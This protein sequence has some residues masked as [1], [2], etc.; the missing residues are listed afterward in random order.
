MGSELEELS[1]Y[2]LNIDD[3]NLSILRQNTEIGLFK[4]EFEDKKTIQFTN[5]GYGIIEFLTIQKNDPYF[6]LYNLDKS[7]SYYFFGMTFIN[8][9]GF[10]YMDVALI[11]NEIR[12][13][14]GDYF[15]ILFEDGTKEKYTFQ[16]AAKGDK[17]L[18][19]NIITLTPKDLFNFL[20]KKIDKVKVVSARKNVY[21]IYCLNEKDNKPSDSFKYKYTSRKTGQYLLNYM[22]YKFI[23]FNLQNKT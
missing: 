21:C 16:R 17:Y 3:E 23:D 13:A 2:C 5:V 8:H 1:N 20:T 10:S 9:N 6:K 7:S 18:S 19:S 4:D 22:T 15:I 11:E 14:L 12:L